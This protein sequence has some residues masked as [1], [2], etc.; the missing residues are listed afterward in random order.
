MSK[1]IQQGPWAKLLPD[2]NRLHLQ[3]GP[4]D[5]IIQAFGTGKEEPK[6]RTLAYQRAEARFQTVLNELVGELKQLRQQCELGRDFKSTIARRMQRAT[7][8]FLPEFITPMAAVAGA[9][10]DEMLEAIATD[11]RL[12]KIYVNNGGDT[13]FY[14]A[15]GQS[16]KAAI[17]APFQANILIHSTDPYRGIATSGWRGRSQSLGIVDSVSVVAN[18]CANADAAATMIANAVNLPGHKAIIR[19]PAS[20]ILPES[21]LAEQ[22]VTVDVGELTSQEIEL[23][24]DS[25]EKAAQSYLDAGIIGSA[26]LLLKNQTRFIGNENLIQHTAGELMDG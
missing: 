26:M 14:L 10:A 12:G 21:D 15:E 20:Q 25:G 3:H 19:L 13:A 2:G 18:N 8:Q 4:I 11:E 22:L 5:L 16:I 1:P 9:V 23:A 24:L 7:R 17:A 6:I